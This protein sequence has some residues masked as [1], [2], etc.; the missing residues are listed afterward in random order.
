M[1]KIILNIFYKPVEEIWEFIRSNSDD[2]VVINGG[3][4][5]KGTLGE[6]Y[7]IMFDDSGD[8][9]SDKNSLL[10]EMTSIYWFWRNYDMTALD[11]V[12]FN[13][14]RRF[15]KKDDY[16]DFRDYDIIVA[17]PIKCP[18]ALAWQYS[19]YHN[20]KDLQICADIM[21]TYCPQFHSRFVDYI[22]TKT[23]N[24]APCNMFIMKRG[25]FNEWC[26]FIFPLLEELELK[27]DLSGRDNYQK[28][29]LCFL[30]ERIFGFW[31]YDKKMSGRKV[32]E[33]PIDEHKEY[34]N[35]N[36]NERGTY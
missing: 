35:N 31:C 28:R 23:D 16:A 27:I 26:S 32:K 24:Y 14:Y 20:I 25:L 10:N 13:H 6:D 15:F 17:D 29:A 3:S 36:L 4:S 5:L 30:T 7:P 1:L 2:L 22:N 12:G 21:K 19:Y 33:I 11:Y 18:Y 9:I 34:K 8:N